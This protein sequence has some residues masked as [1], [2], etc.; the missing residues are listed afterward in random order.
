M[1]STINQIS[2]TVKPVLTKAVDRT[3]PVITSAIESTIKIVERIDPEARQRDAY[4]NAASTSAEVAVDADSAPSQEEK[5]DG[6]A[7]A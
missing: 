4:F 6:V 2:E 3:T 1:Q 5:K 7:A